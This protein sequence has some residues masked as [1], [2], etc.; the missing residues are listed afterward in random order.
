MHRLILDLHGSED[1]PAW[2][3]PSRAHDCALGVYPHP[4]PHMVALSLCTLGKAP[5]SAW[6]R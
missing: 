4:Y 1:L 3:L 5:C 2:Y 6:V